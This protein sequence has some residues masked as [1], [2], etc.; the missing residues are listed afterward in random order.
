MAETFI[1]LLPGQNSTLKGEIIAQ[2]VTECFN[3]SSWY[4]SVWRQNGARCD[5]TYGGHGTV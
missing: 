2:I 5:S 3:L 1:A 4:F